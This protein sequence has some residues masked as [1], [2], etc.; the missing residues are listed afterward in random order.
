MKAS[1][2]IYSNRIIVNLLLNISTYY[3]FLLVKF[4]PKANIMEIKILGERQLV[5]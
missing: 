4:S 3:I 5:L 1:L 2:C